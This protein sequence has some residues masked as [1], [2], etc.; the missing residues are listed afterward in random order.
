[1][2]PPRNF[3]GRVGYRTTPGLPDGAVRVY[4]ADTDRW[5]DRRLT[6]DDLDGVTGG[7]GGSG[8]VTSVA[9]AAPGIFAVSGSPVTGAG[10]LTL[11]LEAQ[12]ANHFW[13]GPTSGSDAAPTFRALAAADLPAASLPLPFSFGVTGA[14]VTGDDLFPPRYVPY[15]ATAVLLELSAAAN[16]AGDLTVRV[17]RS[18]DGGSTFPDTVGTITLSTGNRLTTSTTITTASLLAGDWLRCDITAITGVVSF[19]LR[20]ETLSGNQ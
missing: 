1:M 11:A 3:L 16:V 4:E 12:A 7:G 2:P 18:S 19:S 6:A 8:T 13:A 17:K 5:E 10:T 14:N 15:D 9:L 20:I